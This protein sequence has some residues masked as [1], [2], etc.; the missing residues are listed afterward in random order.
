MPLPLAGQLDQSPHHVASERALPMQETRAR[1]R[2]RGALLG[3]AL[4]GPALA[5]VK[6]YAFQLVQKELQ[7]G[8]AGRGRPPRYGGTPGRACPAMAPG[9][10]RAGRAPRISPMRRSPT[11]APR[12]GRSNS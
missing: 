10:S 7:M 4:T 9:P 8:E 2:P 12:T 1:A 6:D 5:D 11:R 3:L